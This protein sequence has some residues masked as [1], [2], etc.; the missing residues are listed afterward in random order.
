MLTIPPNQLMHAVVF[1]FTTFADRRRLQAPCYAQPRAE[2]TPSGVSR[3][4]PFLST[5][6]GGCYD[7]VTGQWAI[8]EGAK[9]KPS[10]RAMKNE[11]SQVKKASLR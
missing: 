11:S 3:D 7:G 9:D 8:F 2:A 5:Q 10:A 1:C 6:L 4:Y